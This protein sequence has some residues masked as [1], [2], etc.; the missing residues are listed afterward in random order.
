M[1]EVRALHSFS[2]RAGAV[3]AALVAA[4]LAAYPIQHPHAAGPRPQPP[5]TRVRNAASSDGGGHGV[6]DG[7]LVTPDR[8]L[9]RPPTATSTAPAHPGPTARVDPQVRDLPR[10]EHLRFLPRC[11]AGQHRHVRS[12]W[13]RQHRDS[14][15]RHQRTRHHRPATHGLHRAAA[16]GENRL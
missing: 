1:A 6:G 8:A 7:R 4:L 10:A 9:P 14:P 5:A 11:R 13:G 15:R 2:L 3:I 16:S 12:M